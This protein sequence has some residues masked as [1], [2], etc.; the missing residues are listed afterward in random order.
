VETIFDNRV[1]RHLRDFNCDLWHNLDS[2][3]KRIKIFAIRVFGELAFN[4]TRK[5]G[6]YTSFMSLFAS[7]SCFLSI[8]MNGILIF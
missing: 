8:L 5:S 6:R 2:S 3:L 7:A 1:L 4:A